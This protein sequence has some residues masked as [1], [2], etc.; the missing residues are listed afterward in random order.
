MKSRGYRQIIEKESEI[1][2]FGKHRYQTI[3]HVLREEPSYILWLQEEKIVKFTQE[4][5]DKAED[6]MRDED[7]EGIDYPGPNYSSYYDD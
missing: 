2:L 1:L 6:R 4:I 7:G 3:Q 5:L